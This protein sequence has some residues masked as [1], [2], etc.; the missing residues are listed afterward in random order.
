MV[1]FNME[2]SI[3]EEQFVENEHLLVKFVCQSVVYD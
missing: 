2:L 3:Y 1:Y